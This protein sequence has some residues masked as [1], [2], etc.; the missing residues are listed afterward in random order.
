M[1]HHNQIIEHPR[2]LRSAS[3]IPVRAVKVKKINQKSWFFMPVFA[4][5]IGLLLCYALR[6]RKIVVELSA[7]RSR[8]LPR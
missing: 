6:G 2:L 3:P 4:P 8:F 5:K 1:R 7:S